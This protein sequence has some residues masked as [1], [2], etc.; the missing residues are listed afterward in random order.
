MKMSV[1]PGTGTPSL[2]FKSALSG[3][4]VYGR[5]AHQKSFDLRAIDGVLTPAGGSHD[6]A[7]ANLKDDF[8]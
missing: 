7:T 3:R 6:G 4:L 5:K 1:H 8:Q 2:A